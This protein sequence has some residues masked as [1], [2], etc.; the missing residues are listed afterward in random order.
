MGIISDHVSVD[1]AGPKLFSVLAA[2]GIGTWSDFAAALAAIYSLVLIFEWLWKRLGRPACE[3][4]GWL[5][6][7]HRRNT[8]AK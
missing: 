1:H 3:H 7:R 6:P 8:D 5:K 4:W 2:A